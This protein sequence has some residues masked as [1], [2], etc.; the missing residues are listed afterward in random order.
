[1]IKNYISMTTLSLLFAVSLLFAG[2]LSH[3]QVRKTGSVSGHAFMWSDIEKTGY[4]KEVT[5]KRSRYTKHFELNDGSMKMYS[6]PGSM[7]YQTGNTWEEI[8]LGIHTNTSGVHSSHPYFNGDNS[9]KTWYPQ[10]PMSGKVYTSVKD[11]DMSE[12]IE[13]MYAIDQNGNTVYQYQANT[14]QSVSVNNNNIS[15]TNLFPNTTVSYAQQVD[16][17]KFNVVLESNQALSNLPTNAKFLVIK[18]KVTIPANWTVRENAGYINLFAGNT[19]VANMLKPVA[20]EKENPEKSYLNDEDLMIEGTMS[21]TRSGNVLTIYTKYPIEWLKQANRQFPVNLDPTTNFYPPTPVAPL[22]PSTSMVTGRLTTAT[23][24]NQSGFLRVGAA[25]TYGWAKFNISTLPAGATITTA[26]YFGYQY[27]PTGTALDKIVSVVG[28]QAVDPEVVV[29]SSTTPVISNQINTVGPVYNSTYVFGGTNPVAAPFNWRSAAL[30]GNATADISNQQAS[31]GWTCLGFKYT[32]GNT[33]TMLQ[34][35][36]EFVITAPAE[37]P[38]LTLVY[39]T[40]SCT[41]TPVAGTATAT[42]SLACGDPFTLNLVGNSTGSL[43]TFQWQSSPVGLN[44][45]TNLGTAQTSPNYT[46]TQSSPQ[47]YQCIVTCTAPGGASSTSTVLSLGQNTVANCYCIP[48][49]PASSTNYINGFS[50]SGAVVN[51]TNTGTTYSTSPSAGYGNYTNLVLSANPTTVINFTCTFVAGSQLIGLWADWNQDGDFNDPGENP[52]LTTS[53]GA[54]PYSNT[55]TI[56]ATAL[57]GTTRLRIRTTTLGT[58]Q[59]CGFSANGETEDYTINVLSSGQISVPMATQPGLSYTENFADITN[60]TNAFAAGIGANRWSSVAVNATG[61]IPSATRVATATATFVPTTSGGVQRGT[62]NIILLATGGTDNTTSAA[63]DFLMNFTGV[64]AGTMSF[65]A[66][67]VFNSTGNRSG[68]LHVYATTDNITWTE[69]TG[70]NLPYVATNNVAGSAVISNIALPVNFNSSATARLRFYVHNSPGIAGAAGSRPKISIDNVTV[71][72]INPTAPVVTSNTATATVDVPFLYY[73]SASNV[74]TSFTATSLPVG[75]IINTLTGQITGTPTTAAASLA[76][77]MT[78]S[79][80]NGSG[81]GTLTLT[82]NPGSQTISFSALTAVTYGDAPFN[83]TATGGA[84][85]SPVTFTSSDSFVASVTGN[86]ITIVG[87]GTANITASQAGD[88]NY[89]AATDVVRVLTVNQPIVSMTLQNV[90]QISPSVFEYD[91]ML[92]NT[93]NTALALKG[94]SC[95]INHAAGMR[96][97]GTLT[98]TFIS[99]DPSLAAIP[100]PVAGYTSSTNHLRITA[101][102]TTNGNE[103]NL[104]PSLPVRIATMRVSNSVPFPADFIPSLALQTLT[105]VGKTACIANCIVT[106]PGTLYSI[107]GVGNTPA[108]GFI[109]GLTGVVNTPC[110]YLNKTA[111]FAASMSQSSPVSCY[112]QSDGVAQI[113]SSGTGSSSTGMYSINGGAMMPY[114]SNPFS[115]SNLAAATYTVALTSSNGC[116]SSSTSTIN[117]PSLPTIITSVAACNSYTWQGVTYTASGSATNTFI[118]A[119]GCDSIHTKNFLINYSYD[120]SSSLAACGSYSWNG[121]S[122]TTSGTYIQTYTRSTGCDSTLTLNLTVNPIPSPSISASGPLTFCDGMTV[123]LNANA[124]SGLTY[125]WKKNGISILGATSNAY[126]ASQS[127]SYTVEETN[128]NNCSAASSPQAVTVNNCNVSLQLKLFIQGYYDQASTMLPVLLNQLASTNNTITDTILV[129]LHNALYPFDLALSKKAV[130]HT[131]GSAV[132]TF[133]YVNGNY[134]LGNLY[135]V[136][137]R[138]RNGLLTW[139]A[140]PIAFDSTTVV[141]DFSSSSSKAYGDNMLEVEPGVWAMYSA[142]LN[143]DQNVDLLDMPILEA[144]IAEYMFGYAA[145]DLNGDGNTDLLDVIYMDYGIAN[146]LFSMYPVAATLPTVS[147][148]AINSITYTTASS[149]GIISN[150]G[151]ATITARGIC[152]S[153]SPNPTVSLSTKTI[154]GIGSG[155]FSSNIT[156]LVAGTAYY[157]RAYATN[158]VGTVYGSQVVFTTTSPV[159][160]ALNT[161]AVSGITYNSASSG[162]NITS[163]GGATITARGVCWS[164][165]TNPTVSLST[166]TID[167][168]G[169]GSFSSNITGLVAS[170]TYYVRAYATNSVGTAYGSQLVFT[171]NVLLTI[172]LSYQGGKIAYILQPGD[173]GYDTNV[174]HGLIA[175]PS[176]QSTSAEWGC[177]GTTISGADG[178]AIGT[179]NQNTI[180][181]MNGCSTAGIAARICGD[182]VLNG[183][184]DW[185]LPSRDEL[186]KLYLNQTIIGGFASANYWSSSEGNYN[187]AWYQYFGNGYQSL[188]A[189]KTNPVYV[190]AV[191]AF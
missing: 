85:T 14:P 78:A 25:G 129:E 75:L 72:A 53:A 102:N 62:G 144:D 94:Y 119:A 134:Y 98:H 136:A 101:A 65:D 163:D 51:I 28:M 176:D 123:M 188:N 43:T 130:L 87:A 161:T 135:Y 186:N 63:I 147:T 154:D 99:R 79:N 93:G 110:L 71:T 172:G 70:T 31:Q 41:G 83:L 74:P 160:S 173:P 30:T 115:I 37:L 21:M 55:F 92:T 182:L 42:V 18:E 169:N 171:T 29:N 122:Y 142:D 111:N 17:R 148:N 66:A 121:T 34:R 146:Y 107:N 185:Y 191:R 81:S 47:D 141:Y 89:Y 124:G 118:S 45:W 178:T 90:V 140:D 32:S 40:G 155:P 86:T 8:N 91:I 104:S 3:A 27:S 149:G 1:M 13:S 19:W 100:N 181:I 38:Y 156:S 11:G 95:G 69:L 106:P 20:I 68:T 183:Y 151:G 174:P 44:I 120:T 166:K 114:T 2:S 164:T 9:F 187:L 184:N 24:A 16:G 109:Q 12:Q 127:G 39:T 60:W 6:S 96:N 112:G 150:N 52:I 139:S 116:V 88:A 48:S 189:S 33:A 76:I 15:Y 138:H 56:P 49:G 105:A 152:W 113:S 67:T 167:G 73:I 57:V 133:N 168:I 80:A 162:G 128:S 26:T 131:N 103:I 10:S 158:S 46:T 77:P 159:L 179:G 132:C 153:T 22:T 190:R 5:E 82:I 180:D 50:T 126:T 23:G 157:V 59:V 117:Q 145:T 170:T 165:S 61:T 125:Q 36:I 54:S 35:G 64:N 175:A 97:G 84:S 137:I 4:K 143:Q 177:F 7:H 108:T 58:A